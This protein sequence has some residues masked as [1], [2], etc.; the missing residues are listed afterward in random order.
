MEVADLHEALLLQ[1]EASPLLPC[2]P[3]EDEQAVGSAGTSA[4]AGES[5]AVEQRGDGAAAEKPALRLLL[6]GSEKFRQ[7]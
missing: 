5:A 3:T 4:A 7:C 2:G 6:L 1:H